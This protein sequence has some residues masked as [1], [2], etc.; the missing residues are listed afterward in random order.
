MVAVALAAK[1]D[2]GADHVARQQRLELSGGDMEVG[3]QPQGQRSPA[4]PE[5]AVAVF[6]VLRPP[7][8]ALRAG[9]RVVAAVAAQVVGRGRRRC[10]VAD[11]RDHGSSSLHGAPGHAM[12]RD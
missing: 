4:V 8:V 9:G 6:R 11:R 1:A 10:Q 2:A 7:C 3:P 12:S 5:A